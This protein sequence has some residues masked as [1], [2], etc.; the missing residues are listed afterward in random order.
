MTIQ[1]IPSRPFKRPRLN[2]LI[3]NVY[4]Q[5]EFSKRGRLLGQHSSVDT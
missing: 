3:L 4:A 1:Q 5:E 2:D